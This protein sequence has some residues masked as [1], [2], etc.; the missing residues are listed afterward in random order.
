MGELKKYIAKNSFKDEAK[1][2]R[3]SL[4]YLILADILVIYSNAN[5]G[6]TTLKF[7][8]QSNYI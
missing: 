7:G 2:T 4:E 8:W 6:V 1:T 5:V 3:A